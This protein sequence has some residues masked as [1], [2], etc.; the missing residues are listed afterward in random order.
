MAGASVLIGKI[1]TLKQSEKGVSSWHTFYPV[2]AA[3]L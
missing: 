2:A 1:A 3:E